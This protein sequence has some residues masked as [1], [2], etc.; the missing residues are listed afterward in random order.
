MLGPDIAWP[1]SEV[2]TEAG[3]ATVPPTCLEIGA[4]H[5]DTF[6]GA[7]GGRD[8]PGGEVDLGILS[9]WMTTRPVAPGLGLNVASRQ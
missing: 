3:S 5:A 9:G 4:V 2:I 7:R 6:I 1:F 8:R